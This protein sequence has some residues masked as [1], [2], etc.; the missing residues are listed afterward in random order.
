MIGPLGLPEHRMLRWAKAWRSQGTAGW[1]VS[2]ALHRGV[3]GGLGLVVAG[4]VLH[5]PLLFLIGAPLL[6]SAALGIS[7]S[8]DPAVVVRRRTRLGEAGE[9]GRLAVTVD[10]GRGTELVALRMPVP[11]KGI[12]PV[13]LLPATATT[14][15]ARVRYDAWGEGLELRPDHLMAGPDGLVVYGPVVGAEA[16]RLVLPPVSAAQPGP[17]PP[18]AAGLV[19]VHRS[20][21]AGDGSEHRDIRPFQPGDRLRRVDWRVSLRAAAAAGGQLVPGT[22]HVRE[23]HAEADADLVLVLDTRVDV[24]ADLHTWA[25]HEPGVVRAG[26]SLDT[27]VRAVT[28]LAAGFL[29]QGDRVGLVDLGNP[30]L[31]VPPGSGRRQL[32]RIRH[33]LVVCGRLAGWTTRPVLRPAQAPPGALVVVLSTF[34]DDAAVDVTVHTARRGNPV[35]AVDLLP[36]P[37]LPQ[38]DTPWGEVVLRV[39][40]AEQRVR[41]AALLG[42]G[43]PALTW[44]ESAVSVMLRRLR[45]RRVAR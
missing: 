32:E 23:R 24:G 2:D 45:R 5:Q 14:V 38:R 20:P 1:R 18:R 28:A 40:R 17:L 44:N 21:R 9:A 39:L 15:L 16:R 22:L 12:G 36:R 37:L 26:G 3:L 34:L 43:I 41:R 33:Q 25:D 10:P 19:G 27:G 6:I 7:V 29:R 8:G 35:I 13:H 11:G 30:R 4:L 31:G 42:T